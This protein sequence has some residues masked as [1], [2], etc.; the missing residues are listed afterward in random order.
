MAAPVIEAADCTV[1]GYN[2]AAQAT[3]AVSHPACS[4]GDLLIWNIA[5]DDSTNVTDV[6]EPAGPNSETLSEINATPA[7]SAST[8]V[9]GKCWYTICTGAWSAGTLTFTPAASETWTATVIRVPA[10]EFDPADP[11]GNVLTRSSANTTDTTVENPGRGSG[12]ERRHGHAGLVCLCGRGPARG[13]EPDRLDDPATSGF[14]RGR[15]RCCGSRHADD[16]R[17]DGGRSHLGD[18][19]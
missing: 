11:I 12:R 6:S 5:W 16:Q 13:D 4:T 17:R 19:R 15:S 14:G 2:T 18:C 10:G 1:S 7:A 8:E 3:W 9:R